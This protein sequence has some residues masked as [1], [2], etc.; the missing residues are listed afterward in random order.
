MWLNDQRVRGSAHRPPGAKAIV[1]S[2]MGGKARIQPR[3]AGSVAAASGNE[4][5]GALTQR[6]LEVTQPRRS[7]TRRQWW[8]T[9]RAAR[10]EPAA[11]TLFGA[12][13]LRDST[14][15]D[16]RAAFSG[17]GQVTR[18]K[19][20]LPQGVGCCARI[21]GTEGNRVGLRATA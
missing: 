21:A 9:R 18:P 19:L 8:T 11:T 2:G 15:G 13:P 7:D 20:K 16:T 5:G 14:G 12:P 1:L 6:F 3:C 4:G 10:V 17:G